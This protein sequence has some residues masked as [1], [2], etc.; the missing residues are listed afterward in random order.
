MWL[1]GG[2]VCTVIHFHIQPNYNVEIVEIVLWL[3]CVV[4]LLVTIWNKSCLKNGNCAINYYCILTNLVT[5]TILICSVY[6]YY[7]GD[8]PDH[9]SDYPDSLVDY[10]D[11]TGIFPD[12]PCYYPNHPCDFPDYL[13]DYLYYLYGYSDHPGDFSDLFNHISDYPNYP[14]DYLDPSLKL[15]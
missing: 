1:G 5:M 12:Y 8:Y 7:M 11:N 13:V 14:G 15:S 2:G 6:P 9:P 4:V 10:L 3:C